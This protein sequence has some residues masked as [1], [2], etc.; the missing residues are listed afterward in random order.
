MS[1]SQKNYFHSFQKRV[2]SKS[3]RMEQ[4]AVMVFT[5]LLLL[6]CLG[7][8]KMANQVIVD[9]FFVGVDLIAS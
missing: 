2:C 8:R 9:K 6:H 3:F 1:S 5:L 7:E 4:S